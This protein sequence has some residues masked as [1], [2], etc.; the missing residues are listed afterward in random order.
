LEAKAPR[1]QAEEARSTLNKVSRFNAD[2]VLRGSSAIAEHDRH[3]NIMN[4]GQGADREPCQGRLGDKPA[5]YR[6]SLVSAF[7]QAAE[8]RATSRER[9]KG[10]HPLRRRI[11]EYA[12][13]SFARS[14]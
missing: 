3:A 14:F 13:L 4:T 12:S 9:T 2:P 5:S 7:A 1:Q 10:L 11:P 8:T 6:A